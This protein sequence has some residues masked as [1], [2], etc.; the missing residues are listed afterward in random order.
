MDQNS[1]ISV[2]LDEGKDSFAPRNK[3]ILIVG[4]VCLA[5]GLMMG[6]LVDQYLIPRSTS[7]PGA[8][9]EG[10]DLYINQ[11]ATAEGKITGFDGSRI[12]IE[13]Q[14]GKKD[15]LTLG[16]NLYIYKYSDNNSP[17]K[18]YFD[19][20]EIELNREVLLNLAAQGDGFVVT[21]ITYVPTPTSPQATPQSTAKP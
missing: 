10:G 15:I 8:K 9:Q 21:T 4:V 6:I 13:S 1:S 20:S 7:L 5:L 17:A 16:A 3:K 14:D 11:S 12:T 2:K 19:K 18:V